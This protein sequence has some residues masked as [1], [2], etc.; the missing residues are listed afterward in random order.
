MVEK[1]GKGKERGEGKRGR[2]HGDGERGK[3]R[4]KEERDTGRAGEQERGSEMRWKRGERKGTTGRRE[5]EKR[6]KVRGEVAG[7]APPRAP[8]RGGGS[9]G[10]APGT[11][12]RA[13]GGQPGW[14]VR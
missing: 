10:R 4:E 6:N 7:A 11:G 1:E 8:G 13:R 2:R 14:G 5:T 12:A 9:R 3:R